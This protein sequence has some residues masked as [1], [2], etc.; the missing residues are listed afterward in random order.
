ML[1]NYR[2]ADAQC[3]F[4]LGGVPFTVQILLHD[5]LVG[6]VYNFSAPPKSLGGIDGCENY[7]RQE[8]SKILSSGQVTLTGALLACNELAGDSKSNTLDKDKVQAYLKK[9]LRWRVFV[10]RRFPSTPT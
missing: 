3:R 1:H 9:N 4:A 6:S 10:V 7:L 2:I 5:K 8:Q